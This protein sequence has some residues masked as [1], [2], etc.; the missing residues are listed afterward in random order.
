MTL[1]LVI[2]CPAHT[3]NWDL[4]S[5]LVNMMSRVYRSPKQCKNR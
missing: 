4:V 1:N 3:P 2:L 5:E